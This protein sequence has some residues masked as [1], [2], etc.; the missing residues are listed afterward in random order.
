MDINISNS[1][2]LRC[3]KTNTIPKKRDRQ[4]YNNRGRIQHPND[5]TRQIINT[6]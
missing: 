5:S 2:E 6:K 1:E 4:Q 3:I